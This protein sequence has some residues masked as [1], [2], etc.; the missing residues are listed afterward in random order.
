MELQQYLQIVRRYWRSTLA[1]VLACIVLAALFTLLQKPT[2]T[3]T[4][5]VF[6]TVESGGT[7]GELSQGATYAERQVTSY[8]SVATTALVLDPVIQELGL[9]T[10]PARLASQLSVS[11]PS[12]TSIIKISAEDGSPTGA[13]ELS[14]AVANSLLNAVDELAPPGPE[15]NRLVSATIIDSAL[16]PT[17]PSAPRPTMNLALGGLLGLLLGF[18]QAVLRSVLDTR[19]RTADDVEEIT[20]APVLASINTMDT[21]ADRAAPVEGVAWANAEAYRRL[22][23]NVGFVGLG[24][25]RRS[26]MVVTSSVAGEGKTQTAT[27]LARVLAEAGE[28]VLLVDAD[29]RRPQVA[30]RMRIDSQLG[31]SDVL[32]GR[33]SFH[34]LVID[35]LPG[36]LAVLPA[37][38]VPPNPSELLGSEAMAH[39]LATVERQYDYVLF[40]AP[41]LLPVTDS[42]VLAAQAGGA[43]VVARSGVVRD[44]QLE[45]A[46]EVLDAGEV[47]TLGIVLN[48]V[49]L[50]RGDAYAGYYSSY[51]ADRPTASR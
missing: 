23:T 3:S 39:L 16:V 28:S 45:E 20:E 7:A 6:L 18:G 25:E 49:P 8:V 38:T 15:G 21:S 14:N 41:P 9:D 33:G 29:L 50:S 10:T 48:D 5:S 44:R 4:S 27:N 46:L 12:S 22:R 35:V 47:T 13:A 36:H 1:T 24:G 26:S 43:I 32:T 17:S 2:Y 51:A 42:V 34:E 31:L 11:A 40:D 37:G 30:D 19:V